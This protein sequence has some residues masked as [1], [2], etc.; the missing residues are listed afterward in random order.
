MAVL[1]TLAS[2]DGADTPLIL[3]AARGAGDNGLEMARA[4]LETLP[5]DLR[6]HIATKARE[7][8]DRR[9]AWIVAALLEGCAYF[10]LDPDALSVGDVVALASVALP[11]DVLEAAPA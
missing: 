4:T 3:N 7:H 11:F 1:S 2:D 6:D 8:A 10:G 9:L 5:D